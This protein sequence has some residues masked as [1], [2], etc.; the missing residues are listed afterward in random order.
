ME[1]NSIL[2]L[3]EKDIIGLE[4]VNRVNVTNYGIKD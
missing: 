4:M 1:E 2:K 3:M